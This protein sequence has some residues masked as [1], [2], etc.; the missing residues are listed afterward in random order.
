MLF[1]SHRDRLVSF[2]GL[3][4]SLSQIIGRCVSWLRTFIDSRRTL[5][6]CM[7]SSNHSDCALFL[8]R[9]SNDVEK[10]VLIIEGKT[11]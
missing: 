6:V 3:A 10:D 9:L 4:P 11:G 5:P 1:D 2:K 8:A 7:V